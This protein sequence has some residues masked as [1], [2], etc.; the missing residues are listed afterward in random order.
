V[1]ITAFLA[2]PPA[3]AGD[4]GVGQGCGGY[5]RWHGPTPAAYAAF[6]DADISF[7]IWRQ[8]MGDD[9]T[10]HMLL[11]ALYAARGDAD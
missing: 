3:C 7:R 4:R 8:Q 11:N 1:G 5:H 9:Q 10:G 2:P 6:D